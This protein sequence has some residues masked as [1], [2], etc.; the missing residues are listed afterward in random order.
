MNY[1]ELLGVVKD[2]DQ[3]AIKAAFRKKA[4]KYHPDINPG[5]VQAEKIFKELN[6][7]YSVLSDETKRKKYDRELAGTSGLDE[8]IFYEKVHRTQRNPSSAKKA[9]NPFMGF[10]GGF[11]FDD[12]MGAGMKFERDTTQKQTKA[13]PNMPDFMNTNAQ[14]AKFFG[15]K[16][17]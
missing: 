15:F 6:E 1:Y 2:A 11:D 8:E 16:P 17:R 7:A 3:A 9:A 12:I 5:N 14:F 13:A 4:K 10:Q